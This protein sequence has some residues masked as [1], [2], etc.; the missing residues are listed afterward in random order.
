MKGS[1]Y[2]VTLRKNDLSLYHLR[3]TPRSWFQLSTWGPSNS[4]SFLVLN[5]YTNTMKGLQVT[6]VIHVNVL[7]LSDLVNNFRNKSISVNELLSMILA[8]KRVLKLED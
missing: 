7:L 3:E 5:M 1:V 2:H 6:K 4:V 8:N